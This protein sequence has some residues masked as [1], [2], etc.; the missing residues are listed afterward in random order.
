MKNKHVIS[1]LKLQSV[2]KTSNPKSTRQ[3]NSPNI[4]AEVKFPNCD[5]LQDIS[6][7]FLS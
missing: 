4:R 5:I 6:K 3:I 7:I 1:Y 2:F